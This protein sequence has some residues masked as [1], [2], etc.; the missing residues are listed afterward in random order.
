MIL[1]FD[2]GNDNIK[3]SE[4][5]LVKSL[6]TQAEG[7]FKSKHE[8][9]LKDEK[10][11]VG[12]GNYDTT[13]DKSKKEHLLPALCVAL[14]NSTDENT[15]DLVVGLPMSQYK[16]HKDEYEETIRKNSKLSFIYNDIPKE[17]TIRKV[18]TYPEGLGAYASLNKEKRAI[19]K[20]NKMIILDI[21]GRTTDIAL[22]S[23]DKSR[24]IEKYKS[25]DLGMINIYSDIV[26]ELNEKYTIDLKLEDAERVMKNGLFIAGE[27]QD[28]SCVK[29][30]LKRTLDLVIQELNVNFS[31]KI[32]P[33]LLTGGGGKKFFPTLKKRYG[34]VTLSDDFLFSNANGFKEYGKKVF[35]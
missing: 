4:K 19:F 10:Y 7:L 2:F 5:F 11:I 23:A 8:I 16:N 15:I 33:T 22:L 17:Y 1:G 24:T 34:H 25:L 27:K 13:L 6:F 26:K 3:T 35:K 14:A 29:V 20:N 12:E 28:I 30:A 18:T 9:I 32:Y 21:G 31:A